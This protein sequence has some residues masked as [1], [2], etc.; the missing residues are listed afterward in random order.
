[1]LPPL[2]ALSKKEPCNVCKDVHTSVEE[3]K[4]LCMDSNE[5]QGNAMSQPD[6]GE[7]FLGDI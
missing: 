1:M 2:V 5:V 6:V 7:K 3:R 4:K